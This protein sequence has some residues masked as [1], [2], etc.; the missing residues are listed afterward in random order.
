MAAGEGRYRHQLEQ[1]VRALLG[2]LVARLELQGGE[3]SALHGVRRPPSPTPWERKEQE[4]QAFVLFE[5]QQAQMRR[6][7][8]RAAMPPPVEPKGKGKKSGKR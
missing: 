7:S 6:E 8:E 1:R 2:G 5:E 3:V 4:N